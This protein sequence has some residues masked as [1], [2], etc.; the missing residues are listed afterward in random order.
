MDSPAFSLLNFIHGI[1][2]LHLC[3]KIDKWKVL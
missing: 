3:N 2:M 1:N